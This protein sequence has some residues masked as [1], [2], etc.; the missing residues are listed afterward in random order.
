MSSPN[1]E[2]V[3]FLKV[4][5]HAYFHSHL[6]VHVYKKVLDDFFGEL[7]LRGKGSFPLRRVYFTKRRDRPSSS[8][9]RWS[10]LELGT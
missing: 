5:C 1:E 10:Y 9:R 4:V 6:S 2:K 7:G 8:E 3:G